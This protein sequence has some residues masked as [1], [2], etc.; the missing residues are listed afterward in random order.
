MHGAVKLFKWNR[1]SCSSSRVL[2]KLFVIENR[3]NGERDGKWGKLKQHG[4]HWV[5]IPCQQTGRYWD[6]HSKLHA[7]WHFYP[8]C[9]LRKVRL[10]ESCQHFV[11]NVR[12]VRAQSWVL[13]GVA[14]N[15]ECR[16]NSERFWR[17]M[18]NQ[19]GAC[20]KYAFARPRNPSVGQ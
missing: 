18:F 1:V 14:G 11:Q 5:A 6:A 3:S 2:L 4:R 16:I 8:T 10:R 17:K 19:E 15:R 20:I 7:C 12:N 13:K 9:R